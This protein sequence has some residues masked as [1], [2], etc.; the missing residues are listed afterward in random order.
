MASFF[1]PGSNDPAIEACEPSR[2]QIY[3]NSIIPTERLFGP[4]Y[5]L[6][7]LALGGAALIIPLVFAL[8]G[9]CTRYW[10][11]RSPREERYVLSHSPAS[12]D[13]NS[14]RSRKRRKLVSHDGASQ[15]P[16][17]A[18]FKSAKS[19]QVL[20]STDSN[21]GNRDRSIFELLALPIAISSAN[22]TDSM[23][24]ASDVGSSNA[25]SHLT[26]AQVNLASYG[27]DALMEQNLAST[28]NSLSETYTASELSGIALQCSSI[29]ASDKLCELLETLYLRGVPVVIL[30]Q[31]DAP[32]W[33]GIDLSF[34]T[35]VLV[36]NACILPNGE[37]RDYFRARPLRDLMSRVSK[38]REDR[39]E[40][41]VGFLELWEERPHPSIIRR[42]VK[43]AEHFGAIVDHGPAHPGVPLK[44]PARSAAKTISGFELLRRSAIIEVS[45]VKLQHDFKKLTSMSVAKVL[46]H[47]V[48]QAM[49]FQSFSERRQR[50]FLTSTR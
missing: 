24:G 28:A 20:D 12:I 49:G 3:C 48:P 47:R 36:E 42:A 1:Q 8:L 16:S 15:P 17:M 4:W 2:F 29:E 41:F 32:V 27:N 7:N 43:L 19:F 45:N 30:A 10:T 6:L 26:L 39:P 37:R 23:S 11:S 50:S 35:G 31:H 44:S 33:M 13:S 22:D 25:S 34:I 38:E 46:E 5:Q 21:S 14:R 40:L 9:L 18:V